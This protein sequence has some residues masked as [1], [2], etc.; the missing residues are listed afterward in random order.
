MKVLLFKIPPN[1]NFEVNGIAPKS[2]HNAI[3]SLS[4][5]IKFHR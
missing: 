5:I 3:K 4:N 2:T 1:L